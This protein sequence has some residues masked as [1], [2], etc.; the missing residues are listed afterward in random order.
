[1]GAHVAAARQSKSKARLQAYEQLASEAQQEKVALERDR[2]P[3]GPAARQRRGRAR[4]TCAR[5]SAT[6]CSSTGCRSTCRAPGIVGIIGPN[7]AG[8]TTF[9]KMVAGQETPDEGR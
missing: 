4:A 2:H 9:F 1:V 7:G 5:A 6:G 3:A 8:K